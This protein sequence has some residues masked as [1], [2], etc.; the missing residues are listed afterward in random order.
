MRV[1]EKERKRMGEKEREREREREREGEI[2]IVIYLVRILAKKRQQLKYKLESD[3]CPQ[4]FLIEKKWEKEN[5]TSS[6]GDNER[7]K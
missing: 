6:L 3:L 2:C 1:S 7:N 4:C 5:S